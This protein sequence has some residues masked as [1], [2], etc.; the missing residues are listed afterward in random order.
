MTTN[1][2]EIEGTW[3]QIAAQAPR[4]RQHKMR[5]TIL[6][7]ETSEMENALAEREAWL[8]LSAQRLQD[9]YGDDEPEYPLSSI[10][11]MN[12]HYEAR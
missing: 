6:P 3:E 11:E 4:F 5:L 2:I 8:N 9:A 1:I 12:P 7:E 10:H